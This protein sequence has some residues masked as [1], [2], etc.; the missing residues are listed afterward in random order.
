MRSK[1]R[2]ALKLTLKAMK[3]AMMS[4]PKKPATGQAPSTMKGI[5]A[6]TLI[7]QTSVM[8]IRKP[9]WPSERCGVIVAS[10]TGFSAA[11]LPPSESGLPKVIHKL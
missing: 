3:S 7:R 8:T 2:A 4:R 6:A 9:S 5:E 11:S 10:K 1:A